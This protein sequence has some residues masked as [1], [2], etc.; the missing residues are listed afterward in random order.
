MTLN[1]VLEMPNINPRKIILDTFFDLI[2]L[3]HKVYIPD[4]DR[5]FESHSATAALAR[6]EVAL[7][8]QLRGVELICSSTADVTCFIL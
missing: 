3:P 7:H 4:S 1:E 8:F 5:I 2:L 6:L